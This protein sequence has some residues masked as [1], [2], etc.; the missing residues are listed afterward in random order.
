[1]LICVN[2]G[3]HAKERLHTPERRTGSDPIT[4]ST[5]RSEES[6][7]AARRHKETGELPA[8]GGLCP[9]TGVRA[10][11]PL[12]PGRRR[13]QRLPAESL[14]GGLPDQAEPGVVEPAV[15]AEA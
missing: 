7:C 3:S 9:G 13:A 15:W 2:L 12:Q 10:P 6:A 14:R 5:C 1:M 8:A 11:A 4:V